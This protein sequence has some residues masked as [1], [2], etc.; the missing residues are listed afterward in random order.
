MALPGVAPSQTQLVL[1]V[2]RGSTMTDATADELRN[3]YLGSATLLPDKRRVI[4]VECAPLKA[5]FYKTLLR[6]NETQVKRHWMQL[7]FAGDFATPPVEFADE[8]AVKRYV[9][10]HPGAVGF[11]S[12]SEVDETVK[13]LRVD[14]LAPLSPNYLFRT[15]STTLP[16]PAPFPLRE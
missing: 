12:A 3:L 15:S 11:I 5:R 1:I 6:M 2:Q 9:A 4:L 8:A 13:A 7:V 14:G 16:Q 10:T